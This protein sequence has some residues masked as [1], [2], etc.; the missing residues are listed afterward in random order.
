MTA[1]D[2]LFDD[3]DAKLAAEAA[4][5][6]RGARVEAWLVWHELDCC[7]AY[8]EPTPLLSVGRRDHCGTWAGNVCPNAGGTGDHE[9]HMRSTRCPRCATIISPFDL[10][11]THDTGY[12]GCPVPGGTYADRGQLTADT[13]SG[14]RHDRVHWPDCDGCGHAFGVHAVGVGHDDPWHSSCL[15]YCGCRGYQG[16]SIDDLRAAGPTAL[17]AVT[18][19]P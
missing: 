9:H 12:M 11:T 10:I 1:Q 13:L 6:A 19:A 2:S 8:T 16:P 4:E 5:A 15:T 3:V 7:T 17:G 18:A 14:G